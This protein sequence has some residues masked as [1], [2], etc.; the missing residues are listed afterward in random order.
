MVFVNN[1][2]TYVLLTY[3]IL[4][5]AVNHCCPRAGLHDEQVLV[6]P[7]YVLDTRRSAGRFLGRLLRLHGVLACLVLR[8]VPQGR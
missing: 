8:A 6:L 4:T 5:S 2:L 1:K 3:L 7:C